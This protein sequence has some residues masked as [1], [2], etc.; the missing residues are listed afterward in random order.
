MNSRARLLCTAA[1]LAIMVLCGQPARSE[2]TISD[3]LPDD[4]ETTL[5][6]SY[7]AAMSAARAHDLDAAT[8]FF[9]EALSHDPSN[10]LLLD[11][12]FTLLVA[13]GD[14]E[15]SFPIA[16]RLVTST[17]ASRM[18]Q[19]ALALRALKAKN[20]QESAERL[21]KGDRGQLANL[22]ASLLAAWA[23][24]GQGQ[25]D[26]A[27]KIIETTQGPPWFDVFKQ[28]NEALILDVARREDDAL[29]AI[30]KAYNTDGSSLRI[31][32]AYVRMM[33]RAGK[34]AE[35]KS[36]LEKFS[37]SGAG[38]PI[39][40]QIAEQMNAGI[41]PAPL[42]GGVAEGASEVLYGIGA[43]LSSE[44]GGDDIGIVYLRLALYLD[45]HADLTL[46]ALGEVLQ[47][48]LAASD[49]K[50]SEALTRLGTLYRGDKRYLES[51][52]YYT[53]AIDVIDKNDPRLS[54]LYFFRGIS[55]ERAN[56]WPKAEA[57]LKKSLELQPDEPQVLN[58]L[59]YS[60]VD[61][62]INVDEGT[63]LIKKAVEAKP[64]DGYIVDSLGWAYYRLGHY[65]EAVAQ[66]ERAI[67]LK[68]DDVTINDHLGDAYWKVGR[69]LEAGFQWAHARDLGPEDPKDKARILAKIANGLDHTEE[70]R[71]ASMTGNTVTDGAP[72]D[73]AANSVTVQA[74]DSLWKIAV[75]VYGNG[76]L[77]NRLIEANRGKLPDPN[78]IVP[79][80]VI[81]LP[82]VD[83]GK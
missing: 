3:L 5:S 13:N 45:P 28:F 77:Y 43:A 23:A 30:T 74:G 17:D 71:V 24:Q 1:S 31:V 37:R 51:A 81:E 53:K 18:G 57:D 54:L 35:A 52:D 34:T 8:V 58:Y 55:Y 68:P 11:R 21:A 78:R 6:G 63:E 83:G 27:L 9:E 36:A 42:V 76:E 25:T 26:A 64:D 20:Y 69:K 56:E 29:A 2:T 4:V 67:A 73:S 19:I 16:E 41:K 62:G 80:M 22:T 49:P 79:G 44:K 47:N 46:M 32:E 65:E 75:R 66:L 70:S 14:V 15:Q 50:D 72:A 48:G 59:G 61:K 38:Q 39:I 10:P 12:T 40:A 60:W 82:P 33:A 7:L